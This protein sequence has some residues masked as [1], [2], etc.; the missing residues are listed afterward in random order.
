M[1]RTSPGHHQ[2]RFV[3]A[4]FADF[5]MCNTG[6]TDEECTKLYLPCKWRNAIMKQYNYS[7]SPASQGAR[8]W[9]RV[10]KWDENG[11]Q[12]LQIRTEDEG[13]IIAPFYVENGRNGVSGVPGGLKHEQK[14][15]QMEDYSP[16]QWIC[17]QHLL[18]FPNIRSG[19]K[20]DQLISFGRHHKEGHRKNY[21]TIFCAQQ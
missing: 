13:P 15:K 16:L 2:E 8:N 4:V 1:F 19:K 7:Y 17:V 5:G 14:R 21:R 20:K 11:G 18:H 3:Q 12:M 10:P 6:T 9:S